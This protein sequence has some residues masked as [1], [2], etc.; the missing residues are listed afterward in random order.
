MSPFGSPVPQKKAVLAA[1]HSHQGKSIEDADFL[2]K[3]KKKRFKSNVTHNGICITLI[4]TF[5]ILLLLLF[6]P[7]RC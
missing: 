6:F 1:V 2:L 7:P 3:K 5:Y 4:L